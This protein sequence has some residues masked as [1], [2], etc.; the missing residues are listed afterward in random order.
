MPTAVIFPG[1]GSQYVG[2]GRDVAERFSIARRTF[3]QADA[4]LGFAL[5]RICFEGPVEQLGRT[6]IQQPAILTTSMALY[7]AA[8]DCGVLREDQVVATAGLSLGEFTALHAAG[9]FSFDDAV[10]LV[11]RRGQLMQQAAEQSPG[12]MVSVMGLNEEQALAI[13]EQVAS[14]GRLW[15]AN[16]NCPGQ[17][18][19]SG[20]KAACDAALPRIEA[21]GGKGVPLNVAGAF[22][23]EIMRSAA[24]GLR[25][26]LA[27]LRLEKPRIRVVANLDA[28]YHGDPPAIRDSLARLA[29][30]PVRWQACMERLIA[31]GCDAFWEVGPGRVLTSLMRKISRK[32]KITNISTAADL[33]ALPTGGTA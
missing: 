5:S 3:E 1:Q 25:A 21:L 27:P 30:S 8:L 33:A 26:T 7:R 9:T 24:D 10:R 16:F 18:V 17:I 32:T 13:C 11:Y 22:H 14:V 28:D 6:D 15:P 23:S 4:A 29:Y 19:I 31:D 20:D 2:M 12:G